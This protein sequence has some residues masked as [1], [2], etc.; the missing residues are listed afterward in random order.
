MEYQGTNFIFLVIL[1]SFTLID[2]ALT[3]FYLY[4]ITFFFIIGFLVYHIFY[5]GLVDKKHHYV[6]AITIAIMNTLFDIDESTDRKTSGGAAYLIKITM[7][8]TFASFVMLHV[9]YIS[10]S[11][12]FY[13]KTIRLINFVTFFYMFWG[14]FSIL[15][16]NLKLLLENEKNIP[17]ILIDYLVRGY[18]YDF[19]WDKTYRA[20]DLFSNIINKNLNA[21]YAF[22]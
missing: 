12:L 22:I 15:C 8:I 1:D 16:R 20:L 9:A 17:F 5:L 3:D 10:T 4:E 11:D 2:I 19:I 13:I 18:T 21:H 7:I 6:N 14:F